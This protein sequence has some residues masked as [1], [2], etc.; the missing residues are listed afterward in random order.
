[1]KFYKGIQPHQHYLI[2]TFYQVKVKYESG[3]ANAVESLYNTFKT[4]DA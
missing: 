1:M 3:N 2:N 4:G